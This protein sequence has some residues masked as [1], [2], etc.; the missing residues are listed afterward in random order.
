MCSAGGFDSGA[1]P[2]DALA[3]AYALKMG[4]KTVPLTGMVRRR[5]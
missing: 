2:S 4:G 5:C 3:M 1:V